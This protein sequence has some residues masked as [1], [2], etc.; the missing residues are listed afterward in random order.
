MAAN[1]LD[2]EP[3]ADVD[4][5]SP[6]IDTVGRHT[7]AS[8][9]YQLQLAFMATRMASLEAELDRERERRQRVRE[10]YEELLD[11]REDEIRSLQRDDGLLA[12]LRD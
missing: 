3:V 6:P 4:P 12:R 7:H 5:P 9:V 1:T 11:K 8:T 2:V 10:R